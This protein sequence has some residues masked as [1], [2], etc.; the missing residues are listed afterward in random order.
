MNDSDLVARAMLEMVGSSQA[1]ASEYGAAF[2][3]LI[4][5]GSDRELAE[6]DG[7]EEPDD[8]AAGERW[9][10]IEGR[11]REE[12]TR[13]RGAFARL[14]FGDTSPESRRM[15]QL[16]FNRPESF[17]KVLVAQSL[18]GRE[19]LNLHG[20]CRVVVLLHPE[21]NPDVVEQQIGRV[22]RVNS[23]WC[24]ELRKAVNDCLP[25]NQTP[26]IEIRPV[27]FQG[28]YDEH[29]W[30]VLRGRWNELRAQL[31]G[32]V[33]FAK[34]AQAESEYATLLEEILHA[35]PDFS[36]KPADDA[37]IR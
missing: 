10:V 26:R 32:V 18:V 23:R 30:I 13:T 17:P 19:G 11:L 28:T 6:I 34:A 35:A 25:P 29:N 21:W 5:A 8:D 36:P 20:A 15:I 1:E 9:R 31:H 22:A 3:Q 16:A 12:Y 2:C 24:Y 7:D 4:D 33:I 27:I 14:M 37:G